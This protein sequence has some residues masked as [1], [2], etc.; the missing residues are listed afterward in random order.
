MSSRLSAKIRQARDRVI[1]N[2]LERVEELTP[3][4]I[5]RRCANWLARNLGAQPR[6]GAVVAG[7]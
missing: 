3:Y 7:R 2:R 4:G 6:L 1:V 5:A